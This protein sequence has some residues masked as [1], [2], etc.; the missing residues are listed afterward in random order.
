LLRFRCVLRRLT[1]NF[2]RRRTEPP[3]KCFENLFTCP[4]CSRSDSVFV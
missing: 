1:T 3:A 4:H 2:W